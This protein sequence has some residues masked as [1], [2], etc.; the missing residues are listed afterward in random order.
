MNATQYPDNSQRCLQAARSFHYKQ[1]ALCLLTLELI[2]KDDNS[3]RFRADQKRSCREMSAKG[4]IH[5][6]SCA[7]S[8]SDVVMQSSFLPP[9][10]RVIRHHDVI[11]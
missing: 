11:H 5:N 1:R 8:A 9:A 3:L 4:I 10:W 2:E 6:I 7:N